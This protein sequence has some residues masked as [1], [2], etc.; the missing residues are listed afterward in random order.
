MASDEIAIKT[1]QVFQ[2]SE[3]WELCGIIT[4]VDK[5][6]GRKKLLTPNPIGIYCQE[7][8]TGITRKFFSVNTSLAIDYIKQASPDIILIFAFGQLLKKEVLDIAPCYNIHTSL[9]PRYRGASPIQSS[10]L[11]GDSETGVTVFLLDEK[12]DHGKIAWQEK[13]VINERDNYN[14]LSN[15]LSNLIVNNIDLVASNIVENKIVLTIQDNENASYCKKITK[16][17]GLL[18]WTDSAKIN[19][20]KIR[21]F[22]QW[23]GCYFFALLDKI[24]KRFIVK[25]AKEVYWEQLPES[26][27]EKATKITP[28][29][30][31]DGTIV[32]CANNTFLELEEIIPE[33]KRKQNS[34]EFL[35]GYKNIQI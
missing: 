9:L 18:S 19:S 8:L 11:N 5:K 2:H 1:L 30:F 20:N 17:D 33:G 14:D 32:L 29:N 27:K 13:I 4:Q 35:N 23:P 7:N 25:K 22:S 3:N 15:N 16:S 34:K 24:Q 12:M 31:V 10:L 6:Q 21:A 26:L 28:G